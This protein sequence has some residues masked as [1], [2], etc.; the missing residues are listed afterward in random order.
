MSDSP[1]ATELP[2]RTQEQQPGA[3][4][5]QLRL[6]QIEASQAALDQEHRNLRYLI[7]SVIAHRLQSHSELVLLLTNL[8]S[9]LPI[10][11]VGLIISKLVEH[12][13]NVSQYLAALSKGTADVPIPEPNVLKTLDHAKKDLRAAVGP[14][15][16]AL[17]RLKPPV[18]PALLET[19]PANPDVFFTPAAVRAWRC[20]VKGQVPRERVVREFGEAALKC[21]VDMTTDPKL[22]PRPRTEEIVLGFKDDFES[23]LASETGIQPEQKEK[24]LELYRRVQETKT[25]SDQARAQRAAFQKLSFFIEL[26]YYYEHQ[27]TEPADVVFAQRLPVL[28][29][30]LAVTGENPDEASVQQAEELLSHIVHPDHRQMVIN[31]VG[32][33]GGPARTIKYIL[34]LRSEKLDNPD[35]IAIE[36]VRHLLP[37]QSQTTPKPADLLPLLRLLPQARQKA[38]LR[39]IGHTDRL[40]KQDADVLAKALAADLGIVNIEEAKPAAQ[41]PPEVERE[42]AWGRIKDMVAQRSDAVSLANAIRER[43][44]AHYE[45]EEIRQSWVVLTDA[46]PMS[47]IRVFCQLPYLPGGKTDPIA[48]P[49]MES[50]LTRLVHEK[51]ASTYHRV[52]TSLRNIHKTKP[53]SPTLQTFMALCRWA[54]PEAA[55]KIAADVGMHA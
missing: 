4:D 38:V 55:A 10:N 9:K 50:Y 40:R 28:V 17:I 2:A 30:Q 26:L 37:A 13:T 6:E 23:C 42:L 3:Q 31:N 48:K 27:S 36:L 33:G 21:C 29:E 20:F 18:E 43:L 11:D 54:S 7:E 16:E 49:V 52:L 15:V 46:D 34:T 1:Q 5:V 45:S 53:D 22:N 25:N 51:Y 44:N 32:K 39:A 8:V 35:P 41:V 12:N 19:L 24:L 47:F 14:L